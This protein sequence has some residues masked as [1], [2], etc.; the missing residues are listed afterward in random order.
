MAL[1]QKSDADPATLRTQVTSKGGTTARA[2]ATLE[3]RDVKASIVVAAKDAAA[4]AREL[5]EEFGKD[6]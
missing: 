2:L 3:A 6:E 5:G 1:A 4:R